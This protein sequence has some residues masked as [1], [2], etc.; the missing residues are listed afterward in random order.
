MRQLQTTIINLFQKFTY[1]T[2]SRNMDAPETGLPTIELCYTDLRLS[3]KVPA[4]VAGAQPTTIRQVVR[5]AV[6]AIPRAVISRFHPGGRNDNRSVDFK[7]LDGVSGTIRPGCMTLI[8]G[9]PGSGKSSLLR[10]LTGRLVSVSAC[11]SH[12]NN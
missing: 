5:D 2:F 8:I 11:C 1:F 12:H 7:V 9:H 10:A 4:A 3:I 6:L